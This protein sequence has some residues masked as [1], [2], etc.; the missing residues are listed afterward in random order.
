MRFRHG[1][2][3]S[4][5]AARLPHRH[6]L[7][8]KRATRVGAQSPTR[9]RL[10]TPPK[11]EGSSIPQEMVSHQRVGAAT[12]NSCDVNIVYAIPILDWADPIGVSVGVLWKLD[13][14]RGMT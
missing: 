3:C 10:A 4:R 13:D 1:L 11:R 6:K 2:G 8:R 7:P 12:S 9:R 14:L 5:A